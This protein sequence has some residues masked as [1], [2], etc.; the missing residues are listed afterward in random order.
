MGLEHLARLGSSWQPSQTSW[1]TDFETKPRVQLLPDFVQGWFL[2]Q[3]AGLDTNEKNMIQSALKNDYRFHRVAQELRCQ[4]NDEDLRKRDQG[5]R[6]TAW[7]VEEEDHDPFTGDLESPDLS[8]LAST[9]LNADGLAL[10]NEAEL[11][12][13]EALAMM[14]KGRRTLREARARQQYV[15]LSRQYYGNPGRSFGKGAPGHARKEN[16]STSSA[17]CLSCGGQ[18]RTDECPKKQK[19]FQS[20]HEPDDQAPF[21]CLTD[22]VLATDYTN[23]KITTQQAVLQGKAVVDG[24]ATRTLGSVVALEHLMRLNQEQSGKDGLSKLDTTQRP[25]FG[26]GNSSKDQCLSTA[27]MSIQAGGRSGQLK[28]HT[29]DKGSGPILFSIETLRALGAIIDFE[30]DMICFRKLDPGR[31]IQLEQSSSGH[32]LIPLTQDW[33]EASSPAKEPVCSLKDM[34]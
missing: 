22:Q 1:H 30:H 13:Q 15:K 32:Q 4:W 27:W 19:S 12:A 26:F 17:R 14:E 9:G 16:P 28:V 24:G 2:L 25:V 33:Y 31:I 5:G 23:E 18:H 7:T 8:L 34:I 6:A 3:D 20:Q 10:V 21:I 29:L 11:D